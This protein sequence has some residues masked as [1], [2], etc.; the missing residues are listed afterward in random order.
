MAQVSSTGQSAVAQILDLMAR[1]RAELFSE[2]AEITDEQLWFRAGPGEWSIGE[3]IDHLRA[4]YASML[5]WFQV[6][7]VAL[8][9]LARLRRNRPYRVEIDNVYHR[10]G[11][12]QKVGWMW[13]PRYTPAR[14]VPLNT[15]REGVEAIQARVHEFYSSKDPD[16][17][18]H[19]VLWDPA[20][21]TLNLIQAIRVGVYHDEV[22]IDSIRA[23]MRAM[24]NPAK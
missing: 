10:P 3:N 18:G 12:P 22:H 13:P 15:L 24:L 16:L 17:L 4:I 1:Q 8:S 23:M 9:P 5:P 20:I 21:G 14:P 2:L 7:W 19:V 11:F 6:A